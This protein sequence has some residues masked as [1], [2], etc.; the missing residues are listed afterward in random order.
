MQYIMYNIRHTHN[1]FFWNRAQETVDN[2]DYLY[3]PRVDRENL[4]IHIYTVF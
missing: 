4:Y 1:I 3:R 2:D